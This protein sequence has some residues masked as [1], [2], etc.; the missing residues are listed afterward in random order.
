MNKKS[1]CLHI[2]IPSDYLTTGTLFNEFVTVNA[3]VHLHDDTW[4]VII[5]DMKFRGCIAF[6]IKAECIS[7]FV[8]MVED[9]MI[10]EAKRID[11]SYATD[12]IF[13]HEIAEHG[14]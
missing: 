7:K 11:E 1:I 3:V 5:K 13:Y 6:A 2:N 14:L 10:M 8:D 9:M 12:E 4:N